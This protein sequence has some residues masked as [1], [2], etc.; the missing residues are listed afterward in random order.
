MTKRTLWKLAQ[1]THQAAKHEAE[2]CPLK[3]AKGDPEFR[4]WMEDIGEWAPAKETTTNDANNAYA[5]VAAAYA[6]Y[7]A[8]H[9]AYTAAYEAY[10]ADTRRRLFDIG[11]W[12]EG[13]DSLIF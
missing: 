3:N 8:A 5:A 9:A 11:E 2:A 6:A 12:E 4:K 10:E 13:D 1:A 7:T